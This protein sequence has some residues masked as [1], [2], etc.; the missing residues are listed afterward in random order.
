MT[1]RKRGRPVGS[2]LGKYNGK[3]A[4]SPPALREFWRL[5]K[6]KKNLLSH[7]TEGMPNGDLLK[8]I[9]SATGVPDFKPMQFNQKKTK[10]VAG[11]HIADVIGITKQDAGISVKEVL[12][13]KKKLS[14][15][16]K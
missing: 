10:L 11:S 2:G 16:K 12:S 15:K 13:K 7:I 9:G 5:E 3:P 8:H 4:K 1:S 6:R 14:R